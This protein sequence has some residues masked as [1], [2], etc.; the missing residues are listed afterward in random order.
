M[1]FTEA[2]RLGG[3]EIPTRWTM[4]PVKKP[5]NKTVFLLKEISFD[6]PMDPKIFTLRNL[7][8]VK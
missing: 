4:Q 1:R 5:Q 6:A 8:K 3:R 2:R 7:Q